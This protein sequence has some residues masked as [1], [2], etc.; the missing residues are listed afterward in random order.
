[1]NFW[2]AGDDTCY[3]R[4]LPFRRLQ[5]AHL[6]LASGAPQLPHLGF[7]ATRRFAASI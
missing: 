4:P 3:I 1:M 7:W 6:P 2:F 5:V